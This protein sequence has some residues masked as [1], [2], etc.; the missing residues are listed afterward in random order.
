LLNPAASML[1]TASIV[2]EFCMPD[3]VSFVQWPVITIV[4]D[5]PLTVTLLS[6]QATV[7]FSL[8]PATLILLPGGGT[9]DVD[10]LAVGVLVRVVD[11]LGLRGVLLGGKVETNTEVLGSVDENTSVALRTRFAT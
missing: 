8:M 2:T 11:G 7:L 5:T 1:S 4:L 10:G 3:T 9:G 6:L